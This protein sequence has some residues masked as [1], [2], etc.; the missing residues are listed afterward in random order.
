MKKRVI[1]GTFFLIG[2]FLLLILNLFYIS[3]TFFLIVGIYE[4][5]KIAKLKNK[6]EPYLIVY[7]LIFIAGICS[8][9]YIDFNYNNNQMYIAIL[10]SAIMLNDTFAYLVGRKFGKTHFSSISPNK[11]LEGLFGGF[12]FTL[13]IFVLYLEFLDKPFNLTMFGNYNIAI[14]LFIIIV[15]LYFA[16]IG[17]LLESKLKRIYNIKDSGTIIYGHGGVLDRI[18]SW[19][20][21]AIIYLILTI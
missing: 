3:I 6:I 10:I 15:T 18:D 21:A 7:T 4:I 9:Y 2:V 17:D 5:Y 11:T 13:F 12:F 8:L 19:I 14:S 1:G 20:V 16:D